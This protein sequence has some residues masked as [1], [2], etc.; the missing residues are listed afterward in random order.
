M[1]VVPTNGY[2]S[3]RNRIAQ[4]DNN[5]DFRSDILRFSSEVPPQLGEIKYER[6][7]VSFTFNYL[8][9]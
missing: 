4:I 2:T 3:L 8:L 6:H 9:S 5:A 1:V 7:P